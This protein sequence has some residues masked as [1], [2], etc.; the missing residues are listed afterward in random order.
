MKKFIK[1]VTT[2]ALVLMLCLLALIGFDFFVIG[3]QYKYSY[4]ASFG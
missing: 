2:F 1:K 4:N 3:S